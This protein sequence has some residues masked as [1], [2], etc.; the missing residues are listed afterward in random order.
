MRKTLSERTK[1]IHENGTISVAEMNSAHE[2]I[3][4]SDGRF[5]HLMSFLA[6]KTTFPQFVLL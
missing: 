4:E 6:F 5:H 3:T 2:K 1:P